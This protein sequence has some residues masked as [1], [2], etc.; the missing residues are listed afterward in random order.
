[1]LI[2]MFKG[3]CLDIMDKLIDNN[4]QFDAVITDVPYGKSQCRWDIVIPFDAM[5]SRLNK[6]IKLNG[7]IC[8]F[9][10]EPFS[11]ALRMSNLKMY[12]YDWIWDKVKGTGFLNAKKQPMRNHELISVFYKKQCLYN[13]QMT[14]GHNFKVSKRGSHLQTDVYGEMKNDYIYASDKRFPRSIIQIKSE[15]QNSSFHPTQKPVALMEYLINTYTN[16]GET[17]L[18]FTAG[19]FSTAISCINTQRNFVGIEIMGEYYNIG[20]D[21]IIDSFNNK[22]IDFNQITSDIHDK[23]MYSVEM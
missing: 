19:S 5:W 10:T 23:F 21:R 16:E 12:R 17:V 1:M 14:S 6:L 4:Y 2:E 7:A 13:P 20:K 9:G 15:T 3:D 22:M 8:L 18:D 11:S